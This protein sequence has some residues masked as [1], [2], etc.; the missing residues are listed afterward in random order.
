MLSPL[1]QHSSCPSFN[2]LACFVSETRQNSHLPVICHCLY[3]LTLLSILRTSTLLCRGCF[4]FIWVWR[5][6]P[7]RS[8]WTEQNWS[9]H[10]RRRPRR[11]RCRW[12][13]GCGRQWRTPLPRWCPGPQRE[14]WQ[15][16]PTPV[17]KIEKKRAITGKTHTSRKH[18]KKNKRRETRPCG[19]KELVYPIYLH[20]WNPKNPPQKTAVP[21][22]TSNKYSLL[23]DK[24]NQDFPFKTQR[25]M[26]DVGRAQHH[27]H[28]KRSCNWPNR[29]LHCQLHLLWE[30][31]KQSLF[32]LVICNTHRELLQN[33]FRLGGE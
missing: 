26:R 15:G 11:I 25:E 2:L 8:R 17:E 12:C 22:Y 24:I 16:N 32:C 7:R 4:A 31:G 30:W 14:R 3:P 20:K 33:S 5:G 9:S 13:L 10:A 1:N 29:K 23:P 6:K 21:S 27:V 19:C 28:K 18:R